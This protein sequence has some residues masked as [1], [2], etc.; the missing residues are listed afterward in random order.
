MLLLDYDTMRVVW[1]VLLGLLLIGFAIMDGFD[2]GV[3]MLLPWVGRTDTERRV[4]INAIG[5]VWEGNQTW[6]ILGAGAIFA[7]WPALYA[8]SFS[9]F[10]L[11]MFLCLIGLILRPVGFK[12]RS[13]VES[14]H[15][16]AV[17]D[18]AL[19]LGGFLP[20]LIFGVAV[21]NAL[22]GVPFAFNDQ[23]RA[24]FGFGF[25]S[26]LNP[27]AVLCGLVSVSLMCMQGGAFLMSKTEDTVAA[28]GRTAVLVAGAV[29]LA[30]FSLAG[31]WV[32]FGLDGYVITQYGP[33]NG[34]S[35]PLAKEVTRQTGAWLNNF[36]TYSWALIAPA[37]GYGGTLIAMGAAALGW[38]YI[39]FIAS[40]LAVFGVVATP[41]VSMFPFFLPSSSAPAASLT[42][43]DASSSHLT[44]SVMLVATAIFLPIILIYT[45]WVF[46]VL[47]GSVTTAYVEA[48]KDGTY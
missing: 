10:Y 11:A 8:L 34:P 44:L 45:I 46:K 4:A 23:L 21:G 5:P 6:L 39:A 41:G 28:R 25:F 30:L 35:D 15:W 47:Q 3:G 48:N 29:L 33:P 43:W 36:E 24:A 13:K 38:A 12:F 14:T 17:W 1:W 31:A 26:L 32:A 27:F 40:S 20:A 9:G 18:G 42:V 22:Q 19:F 16:K 37:L 2:L 7:A